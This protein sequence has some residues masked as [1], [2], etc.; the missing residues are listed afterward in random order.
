MA[1]YDD[2][3]VGHLIELLQDYDDDMP[4]LMV[5]QPEYPLISYITGIAWLEEKEAVAILEG[6]QHDEPYGAGKHLWD[7]A[8]SNR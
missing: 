8:E 2:L 7:E 5:T 3:T 6:R 4:V 1:Y